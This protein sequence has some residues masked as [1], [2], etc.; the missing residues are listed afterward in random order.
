MASRLVCGG[1]DRFFDTWLIIALNLPALVV[2]VLCY[3]WLGLTEVAAVLAVSLNKIPLVAVNMRQGT[4][5][6]APEWMEMARLYRFSRIQILRHVILPQLAPYLVASARTGLALIWKIVLVVEFLG[7]PDGVGFQIQT[8]FQ[9]WDISGLLAYAIA[10]MAVI[11]LV[12]WL[13]IRP[14][15]ARVSRWQ[16]G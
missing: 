9:L 7:R 2:M 12:E 13:V 1:G 16:R 6:L 10:F 14:W 11:Q 3:V 15:E 8:F 4:R 5:A